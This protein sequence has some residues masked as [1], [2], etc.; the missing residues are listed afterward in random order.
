MVGITTQN[1]RDH[2]GDVR[3]IG[4]WTGRICPVSRDLAGV[5]AIVA[6]FAVPAMA[7]ETRGEPIDAALCWPPGGAGDRAR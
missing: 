1:W 3:L 4:D 6:T 5:G 7:A 2:L